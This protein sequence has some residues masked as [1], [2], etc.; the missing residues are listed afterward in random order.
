MK[1]SEQ[2]GKIA[3]A[4]AKAQAKFDPVLKDRANPHLKSRYATL[5]S[6][7]EA[8]KSHLCAHAIATFA[9]VVPHGDG[10]MMVLKLAHESGEWIECTH[11]IIGGGD[12]KG[13]SAEQ[14]F[15]IART[16]AHRYLLLTALNVASEDDDGSYGGGS[17]NGNSSDNQPQRRPAK[18]DREPQQSSASDDLRDRV[19]YLYEHHQAAVEAAVQKAGGVDIGDLKHSEMK[20]NVIGIF[21]A[22]LA[23][24]GANDPGDV[25]TTQLVEV[26]NTLEPA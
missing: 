20:A 26:I 10:Y 5:D 15:G 11:P 9:S 1:H 18:P 22:A 14:A 12:R 2:I 3:S 7:L 23:V 21:Q 19:V 8:T 16:Y 4:L 24:L 6:V 13:I 17:N 25:T